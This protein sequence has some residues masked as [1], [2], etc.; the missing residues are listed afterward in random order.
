MFTKMIYA[1]YLLHTLEFL[2]IC[3]DLNKFLPLDNVILVPME[4]EKIIR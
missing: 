4:S 2:V 3:I 1:D